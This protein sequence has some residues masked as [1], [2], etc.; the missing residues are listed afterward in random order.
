MFS[1]S[2][3]SLALLLVTL[4][5]ACSTPVATPVPTDAPS[6]IPTPGISSPD[7]QATQNP[8]TPS[9]TASE[10]PHGPSTQ[11]T[12]PS[13]PLADALGPE[14]D[15]ALQDT[16]EQYRIPGQSATVLFPDGSRWNGAAGVSDVA[17]ATPVTPETTF[18]TGSITK[19]FVAAAIMQLQEERE[20]SIDDP[21][22]DYLPDYPNGENITLRQLL[23]HMSG[24]FN[25]FLH[26]EYNA[27]VF[28][29]PDRHWTPQEVLD[30]FVLEPKAA[31]GARYYYSNTNFLLLGLVVEK[32]T[33]KQ[34]G[35]VLHER[36]LDPLG[37]SDTY[38]Q[39]YEQPAPGSALGCLQK[40]NGPEC[41]DDGTNYR[42]T[43]SAGT[44]AWGAGDVISTASNLADWARAIYARSSAFLDAGSKAQMTD[45]IERG[46]DSYG[47]G[48]RTR[49][50]IGH[51]AFGHTGSLRGFDAAMWHY[52]DVD[53]SIVVLT[54]RGRIEANPIVDALAAIAVPYS[55]AYATQ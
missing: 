11:P 14:L 2:I 38:V 47:L 41:L 6:P 18:V 34:L 40:P 32:V 19:T 37:L 43:L 39:G 26:P 54:N 23:S 52:P 49:M 53:T 46:N 13:G 29:N 36:F 28:N 48:T 3:L 55:E 50:S 22:S 51:R 1:R 42:P 45:Y 30:D 12:L 27:T 7:A 31:P 4:V 25:Y 20:L 44:V 5:A 16:L 21:L 35:E 24:L 10:P 17:N 9:A 15:Q 33:G 8:G